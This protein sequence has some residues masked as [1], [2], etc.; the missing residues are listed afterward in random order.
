M[1][2]LSEAWL[3]HSR[4]DEHFTHLKCIVDRL[5]AQQKL[6]FRQTYSQSGDYNVQLPK[7]ELPSDDPSI[8]TGEVIYNLRASLDYA[9]FVLSGRKDKTQFPIETCKEG[10]DARK[11][12]RSSK[13]KPVTHFLNGVSGPCCDLIEAVQPYKGVHW[14]RILASLSNNDKHRELTAL[15]AVSRQPFTRADIQALFP[16][17]DLYPGTDVFPSSGYVEMNVEQP[18]DIAL[19]QGTPIRETLQE[20]KSEVADLLTRLQSCQ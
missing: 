10:F 1:H 17:N 11:T 19:P 5:C 12:G 4:A 9:V 6:F 14:T 18:F 2:D 8:R 15:K 3:R 7:T 20:L 16:S 13:G